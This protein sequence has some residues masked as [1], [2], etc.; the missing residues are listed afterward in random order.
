MKQK[1]HL[2]FLFL[3]V[4]LQLFSLDMEIWVVSH[5]LIY[6]LLSLI[7]FLP[8]F[9]STKLETWKIQAVLLLMPDLF[10]PCTHYSF[11]FFNL[12]FSHFFFLP[13]LMLP[14]FV[15]VHVVVG[16]SRFCGFSG[17]LILWRVVSLVYILMV[18]CSFY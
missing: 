5:H 6:L 1:M 9:P 11:W 4:S 8:C 3:V 15:D 14:L 10:K 12:L 2:K 7:L 16:W 17:W 13:I 18:Y